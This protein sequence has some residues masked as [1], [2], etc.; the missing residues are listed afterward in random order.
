MNVV[1]RYILQLFSHHIVIKFR[2]KYCRCSC[3]AVNKN[4][5][6]IIQKIESLL[7]IQSCLRQVPSNDSERL[8]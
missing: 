5:G 7:T 3:A 4:F 1:S 2:N 8:S 6:I